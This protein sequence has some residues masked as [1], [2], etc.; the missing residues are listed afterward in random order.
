[1][2]FKCFL[3]SNAPGRIL[4]QKNVSD[5]DLKRYLYTFWGNLDSV[6][7]NNNE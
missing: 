4:Y 7:I 2:D 5:W 3:R 6:F 1:M